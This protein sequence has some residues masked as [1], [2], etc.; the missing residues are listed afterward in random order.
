[1]ADDDFFSVEGPCPFWHQSKLSAGG[2]LNTEQIEEIRRN[3]RLLRLDRR[4]TYAQNGWVGGHA[5]QSQILEDTRTS[6]PVIEVGAGDRRTLVAFR[7][8]RLPNADQ[9]GRIAVGQR[10]D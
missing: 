7:G 1:M 8:V 9:S 5:E 10:P 3:L 2:R 6:P 4:L